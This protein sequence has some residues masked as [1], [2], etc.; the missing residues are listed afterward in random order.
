MLTLPFQMEDQL[1]YINA[2]KSHKA[3]SLDEHI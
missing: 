1:K 2:L 3:A